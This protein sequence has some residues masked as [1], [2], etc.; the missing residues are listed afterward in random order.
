MQY[1][2]HRYLTHFPVK[3]HTSQG[4]RQGAVI[5]VNYA[6]A[7]LAGIPRLNRGEKLQFDVLSYR[8][9][10]V[11][12]WSKGNQSGVKFRQKLGDLQLDT[13]R[14][15]TSPSATPTRGRVGFAFAEMC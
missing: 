6:G 3:V 2:P 15:R 10:A 11:V 8:I 12:L 5:D 14:Q 9:D 7:R 1:R 4:I 13:I